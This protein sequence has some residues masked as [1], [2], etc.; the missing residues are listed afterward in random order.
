[1]NRL[2]VVH[3][4]PTLAVCVSAW[5]CV[6]RMKLKHLESALSS[7]TTYSQLGTDKV[8]IELEQYR[9]VLGTLGH[10][11]P[12]GV[13]AITSAHIKWRFCSVSEPAVSMVFRLYARP[14]SDKNRVVS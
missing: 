7:V 14:Y 4:T 10:S 5:P 12:H 8:N 2:G 13:V 3:G 6:E 11:Q 9:W 1:M